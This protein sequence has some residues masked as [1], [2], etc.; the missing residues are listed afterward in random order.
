MHAFSQP[1]VDTR[2]IVNRYLYWLRV[3]CGYQNVR[4]LPE[5]RWAGI[6]SQMFSHAVIVGRVGSRLGIDDRWCYHDAATA[7][8]ALQAWDG[9]GEP[10]GWHRHP[11]SGRRRVDQG[12]STIAS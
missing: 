1:A 6:W 9:T 8:M 10:E 3:D 4:L 5:G 2:L 12:M 7:R 11:R